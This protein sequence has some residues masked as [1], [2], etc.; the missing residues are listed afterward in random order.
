MPDVRTELI[1]AAVFVSLYVDVTVRLLVLLEVFD[2]LV[3]R[4]RDVCFRR[5]KKAESIK[6]RYA[7]VGQFYPFPRIFMCVTSL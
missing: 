2:P 6:G 1:E 3:K 4:P 7:L 5:P